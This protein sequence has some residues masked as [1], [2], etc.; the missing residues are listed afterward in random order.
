MI[1]LCGDVGGTRVKM[2][3]VREGRVLARTEHLV[4]AELGVEPV[5]SVLRSAWMDLLRGLDLTIQ[6]CSGIAIAFPS[7]MDATGRVLDAFGKYP[8]AVALDF[9]SWARHEFD[10][11]LAIENDAR[12]ALIGEWKYGAARGSENVVMITLGT[13]LGTAAVM[14][15]HLVR[16]AHGQAGV[17]GGHLS[18]HYG[19]REC[20]CGNRGCAEAEASTLFLESI[21]RELPEWPLSSVRN[22]PLSYA[23]VFKQAAAGDSCA[24]RLQEHSLEVWGTL[25]VNLVHAYDPEVVVL[26]GGIMAAKDVILP[27]ITR[28]IHRHA[29]TPWGRVRVVAGELGDAAALLAGEWLL[30][31]QGRNVK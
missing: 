5:L 31:E 2:G 1:A 6:Q 13:G 30:E 11:S 12:M 24:R 21:A 27:A 3:V 16:G 15:G 28:H 10:L 22:S 26:G 8:D 7:L 4:A 17:L 18:V 29:H 9:V 23:E 14:E 25:A 19:G 20:N